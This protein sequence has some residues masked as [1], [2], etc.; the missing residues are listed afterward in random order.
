MALLQGISTAD[1]TRLLA[2][3]CLTGRH[4]VVVHAAIIVVDDLMLMYSQQEY[5]FKQTALNAFKVEILPV[6]FAGTPPASFHVPAIP[7]A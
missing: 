7:V 4:G 5:L 2:W 6:L 3:L 1:I